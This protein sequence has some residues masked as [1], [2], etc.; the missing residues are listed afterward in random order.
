MRCCS[1]SRIQ[2][3]ESSQL[4]EQVWSDRLSWCSPWPSGH[5][6]SPPGPEGTRRWRP[7]CC[8]G[9]ASPPCPDT[10]LWRPGSPSHPGSALACWRS[11]CVPGSA[12]L[13]SSAHLLSRLPMT[14]QA[15]EVRMER[16][17]E[18]SLWQE[19]SRWKLLKLF[20]WG[21][22]ETYGEWWGSWCLEAS[23]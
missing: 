19:F 20:H 13:R 14:S 4:S 15:K 3:P 8:S 1:I 16:Q 23:Q 2:S 11:S 9:W 7:S 21:I 12:A 17:T 18:L 10:G 22:F 6:R 5:R